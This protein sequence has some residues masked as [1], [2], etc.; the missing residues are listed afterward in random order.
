MRLATFI[1]KKILI[2]GAGDGLLLRDILIG[3][4]ET[5]SIT[6]VELDPLV[7]KMAQENPNWLALNKNSL[8]SPRVQLVTDDAFH[9]LRGTKDTWDAVFLDFPY[10]FSF[11]VAKLF[12]L[13]FYRLIH[14]RLAPQSFIVFDFP[15]HGNADVIHATLRKVPFRSIIA[16]EKGETF[17]FATDLRETS[18]NFSEFGQEFQQIDLP[19]AQDQFV[20]SLFKPTLPRIEQ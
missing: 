9:F 16:Y 15:L 7:L 14:K 3:I 11:E 18:L 8:K 20:H 4:P 17:V 19:P 13:E 5:S 6:M 12:S 2:L 10:P 1:P